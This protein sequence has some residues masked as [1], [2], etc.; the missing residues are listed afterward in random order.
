MQLTHDHYVY[1]LVI[2][3]PWWW[4]VLYYGSE[5]V[6]GAVSIVLR[7]FA[8]SFAFYAALL[9]WRKKDVA[10]PVIRKKVSTA[11]LL[12]A[13]FF[14]ALIPSI[15]A[16]FVYNLPTTVYL[17]YFEHTPERILLFGTAIPCLAI[18]L[19]VPPLLLKLRSNIKYEAPVQEIIKWSALT[20][21]AYLFVMFWF[22][23]SMLWAATMVPYPRGIRI[24]RLKLPAATHKPPEF[25]RH[26]FRAARVSRS[27]VGSRSASHQKTAP[28]NQLTPLGRSHG[29]FRQLL[30]LQHP[31]LLPHRNLHSSSE[32]LV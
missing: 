3:N 1:G 20:G 25:R 28:E 11:L 27:R 17:F 21:V 24:I 30:P 16:A 18:V 12:E 7:A 9:W 26:G 10:L 22:N 32:R 14:L 31:L 8:G 19:V 6:A 15:I 29:G 2:K 4:I 5:G 23:Y 13:G